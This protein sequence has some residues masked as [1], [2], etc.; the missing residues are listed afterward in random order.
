[1]PP[2]LGGLDPALVHIQ[3]D[4]DSDTMELQQVGGDR[5]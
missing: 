2:L 5:T 3:T 1:M 4:S